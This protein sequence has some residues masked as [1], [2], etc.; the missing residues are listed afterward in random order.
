MIT[1]QEMLQYAMARGFS[2]IILDSEATPANKKSI[3]NIWGPSNSKSPWATYLVEKNGTYTFS[4]AEGVTA[5]L[6]AQFPREI[7][8][9]DELRDFLGFWDEKRGRAQQAVR[10]MKARNLLYGVA[11]EIIPEETATQKLKELDFLVDFE[12]PDHGNY[13]IA[14]DIQQQIVVRIEV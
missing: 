10:E 11:C 14:T 8:N 6:A 1:P 9:L 7:K 5:E 13:Y 3:L 12:Q 2:L 4:K